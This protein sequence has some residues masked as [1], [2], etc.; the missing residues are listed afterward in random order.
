MKSK[1]HIY[2]ANQI[3]KEVKE[4]GAVTLKDYGKFSVPNDVISAI[5]KYPKAFRAGSVG[6][7]FFPDMIVGQTVIHP[8]D[9]GKWLDRM[10]TELLSMPRNNAEWEKAYAF[11]LGF[12]THYSGDMFGHDYVNEWANGSFPEM[13]DAIKDVELAK[14]IMRHIMVESYMDE[15]VPK[16]EDLSLDAPIDFIFRCFA[17]EDA[18]KL[19]P[20]SSTNV[21][22]FMI[23]LKSKIHAKSQDTTIRTLD[24]A[25]Y[26][27]SWEKDIDS[28]IMEWLKMWNR[29]AG[30]F[31]EE[32]GMSK[33]KDD[34]INWFKEWGPKLTF[35]PKWI[36]SF[37]KLI[38]DIAE[39]LNLFK[40]IE[41]AFKAMMKDVLKAF[42]FAV[43][44]INEDD[45]DKL[46]KQVEDFFKNPKLYLNNGVLYDSK[47]ITDQL[48]KEFG[49]YGIN[50]DVQ[51]HTFLAFARSLNMCRMSV[52]GANNLNA[53]VGKYY[54]GTPLFKE[55]PVRCGFNKLDI[56]IRTGKDTF[57]GTDDNVYF[58]VIL[59]NDKVLEML[60][61]KPGY[62]DF[63]NGDVDTYRFDLPETVYYDSIKSLRIRK[64]YINVDDD[65]KMQHVKVVDVDSGFC[66]VDKETNAW[67]KKRASYELSANKKTS[68]DK[69]SVDAKVMDHLYSLDGACPH[70]QPDY[71]PWN[72]PKFFMNINSE[73]RSKVLLPL[74]K[75]DDQP[76]APA[77]FYS[78]YAANIGW[79]D[80]VSSGEMAGTTGEARQLEAIKI[81][82]NSKG[83]IFYSVHVAGK[84]WLPYV[85]NGEVA[86]TTGE[87]RQMEAIKIRIEN[88]PGYTVTYRVHM[89]D[90]GWS[91]WVNNDAVAGTTG[92][93]RR[94]EAIEIK[95]I[96]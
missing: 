9:S 95:L 4:T 29:I 86:G 8:T 47:D 81:W 90:K 84:G 57:S 33:T 93:S 21:L 18:A 87:S 1:T 38:G 88:M 36:V 17:S 60:M 69:L 24:V 19:Y 83:S 39:F 49:N 5:S 25:N 96:K 20:D 56:T 31:V 70:G 44:G 7:D 22:K 68:S 30:Y 66:L 89:A 74:F 92:E 34:I 10:E 45:I 32:N 46:I 77:V 40:L 61:D 71:K 3:L 51:N 85:K 76:I 54:N 13:T 52:M 42:V 16:S 67:L 35:I 82:L 15:R 59:N 26:F 62:N 37:L 63:E 43:T 72:E 79:M 80:D 55:K 50:Q 58:A 78:V 2:L 27:P 28:A 48:D 23:E 14:V 53:L 12:L 75:L 94:I 91:D 64:D 6:P 41:E 73:L 11:Y 65:W